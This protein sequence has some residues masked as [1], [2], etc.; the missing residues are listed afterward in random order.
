MQ[1]RPSSEKKC[2]AQKARVKRNQRSQLSSV[3]GKTFNNGNP[4]N[5][6]LNP[7]RTICKFLPLTSHHSHI[8]AVTLISHLFT[9]AF[10]SHTLF[11]SF[12]FF[13]QIATRPSCI[14]YT[15]YSLYK[16]SLCVKIPQ[17]YVLHNQCY[18]WSISPQ[19]KLSWLFYEVH[20]KWDELFILLGI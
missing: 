16:T 8:S 14:D 11:H 5:S 10:C 20:Y 9:L 15:S 18:L 2:A 13:V 3:N 12:D 17:M 6:V 1:K 4:G 7:W 19:V